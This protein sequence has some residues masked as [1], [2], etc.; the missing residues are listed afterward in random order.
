MFASEITKIVTAY[1]FIAQLHARIPSK[2]P[3]VEITSIF[4]IIMNAKC[5]FELRACFYDN[6]NE[7]VARI[8]KLYN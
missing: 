6:R 5:K 2:R 7:H 3:A 8:E 1:V 4:N